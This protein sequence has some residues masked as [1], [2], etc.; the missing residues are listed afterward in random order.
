ME[1]CRNLPKSKCHQFYSR[2]NIILICK[3]DL[4]NGFCI[5]KCQ[6]ELQKRIEKRSNA[7]WRILYKQ[8]GK[9]SWNEGWKEWHRS[10]NYKSQS[11][12]KSLPMQFVCDTWEGLGI[13]QF[14]K[15]G[16]H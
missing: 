14:Y 8:K 5:K 13:C 4:L 16:S 12:D 3:T 2:M 1:S 6:R 10:H 11:L 7:Q 9:K 15:S